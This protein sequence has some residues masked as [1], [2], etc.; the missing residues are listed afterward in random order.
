MSRIDRHD[1]Q[2]RDLNEIA[3]PDEPVFV[4]RG[5]DVVSGDAVRAWADLA[6][7][8][9]AAPDIVWSARQHAMRMDDYRPKKIPDL[10]RDK[11]VD[12]DALQT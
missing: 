10:P 5:Q 12:T 3:A 6:E 4:I 1:Y 8:A 2:G 11:T 9:G 7:R